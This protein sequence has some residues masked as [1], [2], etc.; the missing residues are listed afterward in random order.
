VTGFFI[1][2]VIDLNKIPNSKILAFVT[3]SLISLMDKH[4]FRIFI[5]ISCVVIGVILIAPMIYCVS[6]SLFDYS[7]IRPNATKFI[8]LGNYIQRAAK[9]SL[10]W[11][12]LFVTFYQVIATISVQLV[13]GIGLAMLLARNFFGKKVVRAL[14]LIP[15]M[16]TPIVVGFMWKMAFNPQ[17]GLIS[18][19]AESLGIVNTPDWLGDPKYAMPAIILTDIWFSTPLVALII[20]A[21]LFSLPSE[22][23]E[24]ALVDGASRWQIFWHITLPLLRPIILLA[25]MFRSMDAFRR[26]DTIYVM[27]GGGPGNVT[28]VLNLYSYIT[29]FQCL[30]MG[31]ASALANFLFIIIIVIS[32][33][34]LFLS[35]LE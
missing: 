28:Q 32:Y 6:V 31:Y 18:Y 14:F 17:F 19:L 15:A 1:M 5:G 2:G 4:I 22:C 7:L 16:M 3:S 20:M 8:G 34:Y 13:L 11:N 23:F 26:F 24:A 12:S 9:D 27:T 35:K 29:G 25:I 33:V 10:F 30:D 21:G